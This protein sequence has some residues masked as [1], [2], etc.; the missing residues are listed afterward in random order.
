VAS[1]KPSRRIARRD[2]IERSVWRDVHLP[3]PAA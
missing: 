1:V 2:T 3:P